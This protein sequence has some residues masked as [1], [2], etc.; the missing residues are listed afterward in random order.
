[1]EATRVIIKPLMTEKSL[2]LTASG[3]YTFEV[4]LL[5]SKYD[6]A[7]A[8]KELYKVDVQSVK[9]RIIKGRSRRI[10]NQRGKAKTGPKKKATVVVGKEQ[11]IDIFEIKQQ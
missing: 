8:V 3:I 6:I 10:L 4:S 7:Q 5:S 11:K 2:G 9:T 1:M